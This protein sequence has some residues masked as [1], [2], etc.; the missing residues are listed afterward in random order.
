MILVRTP[1]KKNKL[2]TNTEIDLDDLTRIEIKKKVWTPS[3]IFDND[4]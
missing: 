3:F 1:T 4:D 2:V